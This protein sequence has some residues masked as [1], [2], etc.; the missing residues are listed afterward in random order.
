MDLF[1]VFHCASLSIMRIVGDSPK[2]FAAP[3]T[4]SPE[5]LEQLDEIGNVSS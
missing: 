1:K 3:L 2:I 4:G 5:H